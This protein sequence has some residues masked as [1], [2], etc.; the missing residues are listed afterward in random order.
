MIPVPERYSYIE[1][2]LSLKCN[3]SC[4]YCINE[5]TGVD[6]NKEELSAKDWCDG[7]NKLE[8]A[9]PITFGGGEPTLHKEFY[10]LLN[11]LNPTHKIDMLSNGT[12]NVDKFISNTTPSMFTKKEDD[13]KAIRFSYHPKSTNQDRVIATASKLQEAGYSIGIFGLNHPENLVYNIKMTEKCRKAGVY[14]FIRDFLGYYNDRLYGYYKYH[15]ALNGN[16]KKCQCRTQE[17]L[18]GA[19]GSIYRCHRDLY[20]GKSKIGHISDADLKIND[21]FRPCDNYGL[22]NPCDIKLKLG[23]DLITSK[24]SVEIDHV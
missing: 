9:V 20:E 24:C 23:P 10:E 13:Y 22:C 2:Y 5:Y 8:T 11:G 17:L 15:N 7:L 19:D 12:F 6:R 4:P 1:V 21:T 14:F 16:R 3:F 18:M